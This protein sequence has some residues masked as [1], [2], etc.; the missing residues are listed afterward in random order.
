MAGEHAFLSAS[1]ASAW[2]ACAAY[3]T[4]QQWYPDVSSEHADAGTAGHLLAAMCFEQNAWPEEFMGR[5]MLPGHPVTEEMCEWVG[6]YVTSVRAL[7][8]GWTTWCEQR[9]DYSEAIRAEGSFGTADFLAVS[10]DGRTLAVHDLKGGVGVKVEASGNKQLRLYALGAMRMLDAI[11]S[12]EHIGRIELY[13]HQPRLR[14]EPLVDVVTPRELRL[15]AKQSARAARAA[16][17][18]RNAPAGPPPDS[19]VPGESQCRWCRHLAYC[20]AAKQRVDA[21]ATHAAS[22]AEA[23]GKAMT[24][25]PLVESW[26]RAVR[27]ETERRLLAGEDVP[28]WKLVRG[29]ASARSWTDAGC[30]VAVLQRELGD[31]AF[32]PREVVSPPAAEKLLKK[33][34]GAWQQLLPWIEQKEGPSSVAPVSD[35]RPAVSGREADLS[36][37]DNLELL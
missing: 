20:D 7:T 18:A 10:P 17:K 1:S 15:F 31:A 4:V 29:R 26:C 8:Q 13:I 27:S 34:P 25:I 21:T 6:A 28:G 19:F 22:G 12:I 11:V 14:A 16:L 24:E 3:P 35:P 32:K 23:L 30:A 36:G 37:F 5:E 33:N 2:M 9:V